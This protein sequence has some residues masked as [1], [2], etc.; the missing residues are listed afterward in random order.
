VL[1]NGFI[2]APH[3][4]EG[5]GF[6]PQRVLHVLTLGLTQGMRRSREAS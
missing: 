2:G 4:P 5:L 3:S 1:S 6:L